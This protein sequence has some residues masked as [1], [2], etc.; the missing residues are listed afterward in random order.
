M[1]CFSF[2]PLILESLFSLLYLKKKKKGLVKTQQNRGSVELGE[3]LAGPGSSPESV[4][5][6]KPGLI[7]SFQ[8]S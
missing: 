1:L 8:M 2:P 4:G 3:S 6:W 5:C 7:N